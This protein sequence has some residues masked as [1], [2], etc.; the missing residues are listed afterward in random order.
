MSYQGYTNVIS[1]HFHPNN[2]GPSGYGLNGDP[3]IGGDKTAVT[4][5]FTTLSNNGWPIPKM[6]VDNYDESLYEYDPN[7]VKK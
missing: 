5:L 7:Q 2:T 3:T 6:R 4:N 1:T